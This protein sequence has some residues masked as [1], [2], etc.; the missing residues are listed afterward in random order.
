MKIAYAQDDQLYA[1][2]IARSAIGKT[3]KLTAL[4]SWR[5]MFDRMQTDSDTIGII[6]VDDN[7]HGTNY[8]LFDLLQQFSDVYAV[9]ETLVEIKEATHFRRYFVLSKK[10][11]DHR[12]VDKCS[13]LFV[14]SHKPGSLYNA[15]AVFENYELNLTKIESRR[16]YSK[17]YKYEFSVDFEYSK[18]HHSRIDEII[19]VYKE[20]TD[21]LRIIG[22][23]KSANT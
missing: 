13:M 19:A 7:L 15:I 18:G 8:E 20:N 12:L 10:K 6:P 23:Y 11:L 22:F 3:G 21:Y 16:V 2:A 4:S 14:V 5:A 17:K 9:A 1:E